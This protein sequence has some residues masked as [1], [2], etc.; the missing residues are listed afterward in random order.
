MYRPFSEEQQTNNKETDLASKKKKKKSG[1]PPKSEFNLQYQNIKTR[2]QT[3]KKG[4][5]LP[6]SE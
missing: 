2:I 6:K 3:M 4:R 5:T 1:T